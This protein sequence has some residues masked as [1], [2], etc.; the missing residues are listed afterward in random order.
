MQIKHEAYEKNTPEP[1][2][3]YLKNYLQQLC[4]KIMKM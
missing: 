3:L 1:Y 4:N 2:I